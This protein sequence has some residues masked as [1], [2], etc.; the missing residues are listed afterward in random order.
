MSKTY[1]VKWEID[2]DADSPAEAAA[3]ARKI[4]QDVYNTATIFFVQEHLDEPIVDRA[5]G[6]ITRFAEGTMLDL[7]DER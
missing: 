6:T 1:R 5:K 2:V 3:Q 4:Q 7:E